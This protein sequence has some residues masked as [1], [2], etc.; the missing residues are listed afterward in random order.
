MGWGCIFG[1]GVGDDV[2]GCGGYG[3]E[4]GDGDMVDIIIAEKK[5]WFSLCKW[6]I[7]VAM[8]NFIELVFDIR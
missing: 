2:M 7:Y 3:G 6:L 5:N 4:G 1:T 8:I